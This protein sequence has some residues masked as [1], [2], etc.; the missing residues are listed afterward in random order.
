MMMMMNTLNLEDKASALPR[1]V[2][3][4]SVNDAVPHTG[5]TVFTCIA[6]KALQE[7]QCMYIQHNTEARSRNH[8]C[9]GQAVSITYSE[10]VFVALVIQHAKRM[11]L[12]ILS[13]VASPIL[14]YFPHY[15]IKGTIF[16]EKKLLNIKYEF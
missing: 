14:Q 11:P 1:N 3:H 13:S 16:G 6:S 15:L 7:R 4:R 9:R 5:R 10:C 2:T 12:I 8:C